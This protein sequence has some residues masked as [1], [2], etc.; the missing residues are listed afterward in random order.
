MSGVKILLVDDD[1]VDV[2]AFRAGLA[3]LPT[4]HPVIRAADGMEALAILRGEDPRGPLVAPYLIVLDL[5]MPRMGGLELLAELRADPA[6]SRSVVFVL[7]TSADEEDRARAF[8]HHVAG[9]IVK[10]KQSQGYLEIASMLDHYGR[11]VEFP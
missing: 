8:D 3:Q 11:V 4:E 7:T 5:K 6:V 9:F 2:M 10:Y 1:I